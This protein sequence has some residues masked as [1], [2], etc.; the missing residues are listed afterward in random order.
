MKKPGEIA[1]KSGQY[2]IRGPRGGKTGEE[3]TV[4]KG[5]PL[6]PTPKSG[7]KYVLADPTKNK[8]GK[9]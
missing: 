9:G 4:V 5:E 6:P 2:E 7:Q 1:T 8:S 3:R